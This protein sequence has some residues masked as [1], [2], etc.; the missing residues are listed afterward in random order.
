MLWEIDLLPRAGQPDREAAA[1]QH[2]LEH[3][4]RVRPRAIAAA[5][6]YLV[7][8]ATLDQD[9]AGRLARELFADPLAED[10]RWAQVGD[11]ALNA[12]P[13]HLS[14]Q[15]DVQL[16][17]VLL[18][19]GVMDPVARSAES[20]AEDLGVDVDAVR[21]LRKYWLA[22]LEVDDVARW[23]AKAL[24][25][26]AIEEIVVGPLSLQRIDLGQSYAFELRTVPIRELDDAQ[27]QRLSITGQLY[28][29]LAEMQTIQRHFRDLDR[30]PTDVELETVAQTW[31]EHC[32]HK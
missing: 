9:A 1:L 30:D 21:T 17:H 19:P 32:S 7:Q 5:R 27:L 4:G 26:D 23:G 13:S 2:D 6:G 29:Q 28:L 24:A 31:S 14:A 10:A 3:L 15:G 22:G 12:A 16:V 20:A 18:K 8:G 11:P 25:N